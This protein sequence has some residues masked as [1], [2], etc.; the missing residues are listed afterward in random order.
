MYNINIYKILNAID[1]SFIPKYIK[2]VIIMNNKFHREGSTRGELW[3]VRTL[4][5]LINTP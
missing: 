4:N 1:F 2:I 3:I 5:L